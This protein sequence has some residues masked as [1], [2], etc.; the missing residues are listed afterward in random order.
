MAP[1]YSVGSQ[2]ADFL[3]SVL[4]PDERILSC[5]GGSWATENG[6]EHIED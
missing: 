6:R 1:I 4:V 3:L 5:C 2:T